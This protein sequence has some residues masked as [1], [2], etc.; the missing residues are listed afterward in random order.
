MC[1]EESQPVRILVP[2][3]RIRAVGEDQRLLPLSLGPGEMKAWPARVTSPP[4]MSLGKSGCSLLSRRARWGQGALRG[5]WGSFA[6][7]EPYGPSP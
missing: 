2:V 1:S 3:Q 6:S 7:T 4:E 5:G